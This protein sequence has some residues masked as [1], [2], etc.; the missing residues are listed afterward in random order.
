MTPTRK[1]KPSTPRPSRSAPETPLTAVDPRV[2][3]AAR[4]LIARSNRDAVRI[5]VV[6]ATEVRVENTPPPD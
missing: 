6:S 3:A 2:L 1:R 5:R 4:E